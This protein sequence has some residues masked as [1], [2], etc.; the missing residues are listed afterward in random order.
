M[1]IT[2]ETWGDLKSAIDKLS[3]TELQQPIQCIKPNGDE[4]QVQEMVRGIALGTVLEFEFFACRSTHNNKYCPDDVVLLMDENPFSPDGVLAWE[5][6]SD[7][8]ETPI[9]GK[10]G[11]TDRK[12][13][14]APNSDSLSEKWETSV[15]KHMDITAS[16][17]I[18][19]D[20]EG[21]QP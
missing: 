10:D 2:I 13:Q 14:V 7:G 16:R 18:H 5:W 19:V 6:N 3:Q 1:V 12:D 21:F 11:M 4:G 20:V 8:S 15:V 17:P 9:Y